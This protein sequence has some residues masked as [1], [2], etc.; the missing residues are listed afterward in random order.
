MLYIDA[1]ATPAEIAG[2]RNPSEEAAGCDRSTTGP[3]GCQRV[4]A[5][6]SHFSS[7]S[8]RLDPIYTCRLTCSDWAGF[9]TTN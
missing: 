5:A 2:N 6:P 9:F 3:F 4:P 7:R 8:L 1:L